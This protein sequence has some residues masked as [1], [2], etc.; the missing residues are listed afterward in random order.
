M[1]DSILS[2]LSD[3]SSCSQLLPVFCISLSSIDN[4]RI[5]IFVSSIVLF[6]LSFPVFLSHSIISSIYLSWFSI[7]L[8][9]QM[10]HNSLCTQST[11]PSPVICLWNLLHFIKLRDSMLFLAMQHFWSHFQQ[12]I[13]LVRGKL[14]GQPKCWCQ[15]YRILRLVFLPVSRTFGSFFSLLALE[16][17]LCF[18]HCWE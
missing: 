13:F 2:V 15:L 7:K 11:S 6:T 14:R 16:L 18:P 8:F 4:Y 10:S 12:A 5:L 9:S 3:P 1:F 17:H